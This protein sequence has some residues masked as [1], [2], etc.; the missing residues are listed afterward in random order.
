[1][2][3]GGKHTLP[4]VR[5]MALL[6]TVG[7]LIY[8]GVY[9]GYGLLFEVMGIGRYQLQYAQ[10]RSIFA[11]WGTTSYVMFPLAIAMPGIFII[12][13]D[14]A[15]WYR[16]LGWITL[17]VSVFA[18][19]YYDSRVSVLTISAF[20]LIS[21]PNL[22]LRKSITVLSISIVILSIFLVFIWTGSRKGKKGLDYFVKDVF[23]SGSSM[24]KAG[25]GSGAGKDIDRYI[26]TKAAFLSINDSS[27]HY[28]F[29]YGFRTSGYV[30]APHVHELF[31]KYK[32]GTYEYRENVGT[33][34]FTNLV[35]ETGMVGL[36]L[37]LLNCFL[38]ARKIFRNKG[39]PNRSILLLSLL[40]ML[41][42]LLVINIIDV[43]LFYLAIMPS[44]FLI[45]LSRCQKPHSVQD[46]RIGRC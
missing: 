1:M 16:R 38:V 23:E 10:S 27:L 12:L 22:G 40:V 35:V 4:S 31:E 33:E 21:L 7:A 30:V 34:A 37:L 41:G 19:L 11:I 24:W 3:E 5:K 29:G 20:M 25:G 6:T 44:G 13:K 2:L 15:R 8:F 26:W 46:K 14:R 32:P 45:Q 18:A 39:D 43:T 9:V 28:L 17:L 42:W 36:F